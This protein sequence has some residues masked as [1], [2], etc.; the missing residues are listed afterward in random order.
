M[1]ILIKYIS[2]D[3]GFI[4]ICYQFFLKNIMDKIFG[5]PITD[6]YVSLHG[7]SV[8]KRTRQRVNRNDRKKFISF[9]LKYLRAYTYLKNIITV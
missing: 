3:I 8:N 1:Y 6:I 5:T 7:L 4:L 9:Y 2:T